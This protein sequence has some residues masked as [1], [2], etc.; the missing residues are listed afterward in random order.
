MPYNIQEF[1]EN[2][3]NTHRE[4]LYYLLRTPSA[5]ALQYTRFPGDRME[6][7]QGTFILFVA[8]ADRRRPTIYKISWRT[9]GTDTGNLYIAHF[10]PPSIQNL[11]PHYCDFHP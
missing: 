3:W 10:R 1:L 6:L 4:P 7:T 8:D 5:D 2:A 9:H 11:S